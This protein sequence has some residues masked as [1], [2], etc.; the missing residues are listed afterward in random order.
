MAASTEAD[1]ACLAYPAD[2]AQL[3]SS[4]ECARSNDVKVSA[5]RGGHSFV[6]YGFGDPG[7]LVISMAVF[8]SLRFDN[9]TGLYTF[10]GGVRVGP[11]LRFLVHL[12]VGAILD[13][14]D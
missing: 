10:G 2:R 6:A 12:D 7:N 8:D 4:L 11:A 9:A 14:S 1:P 5:L 3:A 13:Y